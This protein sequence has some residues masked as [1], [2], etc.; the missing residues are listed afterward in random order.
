MSNLVNLTF[1]EAI[2]HLLEGKRAFRQ[3]WHGKGMFIFMR[4]DEI[5]TTNEKH[6]EWTGYQHVTIK[7]HILI[8]VDMNLIPW[9]ASQ[10]DMLAVDWVVIE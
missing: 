2:E 10:A 8:F 6:R 3:G 4:D 9:N 1:G 5:Y 7:R